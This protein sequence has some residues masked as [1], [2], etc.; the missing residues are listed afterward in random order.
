MSD[1]RNSL[2]KGRIS[3]VHLAITLIIVGAC[4]EAA[5]GGDWPQL[6]GPGRNGTCAETGLLRSW[7]KEGPPLVWEKQIGA[8]FSGPVVAAERLIL[9]HRVGDEEVVVCLEAATG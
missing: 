2:R 6:L 8:G 1:A 3:L 4:V 5:R 9:F 7:P